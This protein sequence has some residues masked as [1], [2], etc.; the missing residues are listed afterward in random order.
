MAWMF[1]SEIEN[2]Y[3]YSCSR[4]SR[5]RNALARQ[6]ICTLVCRSLHLPIIAAGPTFPCFPGGLA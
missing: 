4:V 5:L 6:D 1:F 2:P 3:E